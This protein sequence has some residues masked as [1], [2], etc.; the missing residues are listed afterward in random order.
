[1][2]DVSNAICILCNRRWELTA[3]A[4]LDQVWVGDAYSVVHRTCYERHLGM[5]ER[6]LVVAALLKAG[7]TYEDIAKMEQIPNQYGGAWN[8]PWYRVK[9]PGHDAVLTF[10][11]SEERRVG[12]ECV[13]TCR[14][15][16]SPDH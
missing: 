5:N 6:H 16:W 2:G 9:V 3:E 8:T 13:S 14:S 7:F 10:G 1:M 12:K 11:R 15:R 4:F